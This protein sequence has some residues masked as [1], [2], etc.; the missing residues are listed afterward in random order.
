MITQIYAIWTLT[1]QMEYL[2]FLRSL[3]YD[4]NNSSINVMSLHKTYYTIP[5]YYSRNNYVK[6]TVVQYTAQIAI[7]ITI[8]TLNYVPNRF[9]MGPVVSKEKIF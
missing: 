2:S 6:T 5:S 3:D 7:Y 8:F 1:I 9:Q 4:S